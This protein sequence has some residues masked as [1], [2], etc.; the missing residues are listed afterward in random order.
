MVDSRIEMLVSGYKV[1]VSDIEKSNESEFVTIKDEK[2]ERLEITLHYLKG[3]LYAVS[4]LN[5]EFFEIADEQLY[6]VFSSILS[7]CYVVKKSL[8]RKR[9]HVVIPKT[10]ETSAI[11]PERIH[12]SAEYGHLYEQLPTAFTSLLP[13]A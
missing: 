7:G 11:I 3:R 10:E 13:L 4:F 5:N 8:I 6:R 9:W 12:P 2:T 1:H